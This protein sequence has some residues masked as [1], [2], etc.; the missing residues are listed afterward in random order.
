MLGTED[1]IM[2]P[3]DVDDD[4][5]ISAPI[6]CIV[7]DEDGGELNLGKVFTLFVIVMRVRGLVIVSRKSC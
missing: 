3:E 4:L 7:E 5:C 6:S 1:A 2:R